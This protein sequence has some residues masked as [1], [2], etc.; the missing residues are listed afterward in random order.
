M[1]NKLKLFVC[2]FLLMSLIYFGCS[3]RT[4]DMGEQKTF[5]P[6]DASVRLKWWQDHLDLKEKSIFKNLEW[7]FVGPTWMSG[8]ITDVAVPKGGDG[9]TFLAAAASGGV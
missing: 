2:F 9:K 3:S 7:R 8:R 4:A 6:T 1:R 5:G